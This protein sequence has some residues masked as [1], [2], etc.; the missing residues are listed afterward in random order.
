MAK[1]LTTGFMKALSA[2]S[3]VDSSVTTLVICWNGDPR[4]NETEAELNK[5]RLYY[6][7]S[8]HNSTDMII[9]CSYYLVCQHGLVAM[10]NIVDIYFLNQQL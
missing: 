9:A 8:Q 2:A 5:S 4:S 10:Y 6:L 1:W 3:T 7:V